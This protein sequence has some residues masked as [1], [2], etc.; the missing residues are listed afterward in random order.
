MKIK[1]ILPLSVVLAIAVVGI[2][3][4]FILRPRNTDHDLIP[5]GLAVPPQPPKPIAEFNHGDSGQPVTYSIV[6]SPDGEF[7]VA[8]GRLEKGGIRLWNVSEKRPIKSLKHQFDGT[9][10]AVNA[11]AFSPYGK[12]IA[13]A[14][15]DV[16]LWSITNSQ[17]MK[18]VTTF[19]HDDPVSAVDFSPDGKLLAAGDSSGKV[20]V[21]DVQSEQAVTLQHDSAV[22]AVDFSPD[23]KLLAAGDNG[24][25]VIVWD[26]Q[27]GRA[28]ETLTVETLKGDPKQ[29]YA[30]KFSPNSDNPILAGAGQSGIIRLWTLPDWQLQGTIQ[31][32]STAVY[33][34]AFSQYGKVLVSTSGKGLEL[35]STANGAHII[36]LKGHTDGVKNVD[37]SSD[38][39]T[40]ASGG[41]GGIL[42][43]WNVAPYVTPQQL[44][45]CTKVQ[46]IYFVP[47]GRLPQPYIW[48]KLDG[49]IRG[50]HQFYANEME[51][52]GF[53]RKTFDFEQDEDGKAVVYRVDGKF[54]DDYYLEDTTGKVIEEIA[55]Q[56]DDHSRNVWLIVVDISSKKIS[57]VGAIGGLIEYGSGLGGVPYA[58]GGYAFL[59]A[60]NFTPIVMSHELGHAFGLEH[61]FRERGSSESRYIMSYGQIRDRLSKCAAEWLD[62]SHL[63][64]HNQRFFNGLPTIEK[65]SP[66]TNLPNT[67]L[68]RFRLEDADGLHQ[69]QLTVPTTVRDWDS[70]LKPRMV[71]S[72]ERRTKS[73]VSANMGQNQLHDWESLN[74]QK[75]A[76][77]EFEL[78]ADLVK[79]VEL[80]IIDVHGNIARQAFDLN[81]NSAEPPENP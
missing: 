59:P 53:G 57:G 27:I 50:A 32:T 39:T 19:K 28:V 34:L 64:N 67:T 13:S 33:G 71:D 44:D 14:S 76:L 79:D 4:F 30:V 73:Q 41:A 25:N 75:T 17:S 1:K 40:L 23:G 74:G 10:Y 36:S 49:L 8:G 62:K 5:Q 47:R 48:Q 70:I 9:S 58:T 81:E 72:G 54:T 37:F 7:L 68:L 6:F 51:R 2:F 22:N 69:V 26:T 55:N 65:L 52:H 35:W 38:G 20:K 63:F 66:L 3:A 29:V 45:V 11:V 61:D 21:W 77:V 78:T 80:Q 16:K 56:F 12:W 15:K 46:L 24:G 43:I 18:E 42:H 60:S 31:N